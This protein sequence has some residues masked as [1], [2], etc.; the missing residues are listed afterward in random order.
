MWLRIVSTNYPTTS[1]PA[2]SIYIIMY[3][4]PLKSTLLCQ[5]VGIVF[6]G[7]SVRHNR[8]YISLGE[9]GGFCGHCWWKSPK[10]KAEQREI[11]VNNLAV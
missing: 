10:Q 4:C 5:E 1:M 8:V 11:A 6:L 7:H 2:Y 3:V 9:H